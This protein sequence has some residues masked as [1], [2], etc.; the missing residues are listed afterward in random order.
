MRLGELGGLFWSD[1]DLDRRVLYVQRALI[2]GHGR[3]TLES[4]KTPGSRRSIVLTVKAVDALLRHRER[5]QAEGFTVECDTL[6]FTNRAGNPVN[7]SH[8][9]SRLFNPCSS[10]RGCRLPP[11]MLRLVIPATASS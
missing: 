3:Q 7:L 4:P 1:L 5:Q 8:L 10:V 11:S 2:T 6:V 9:L